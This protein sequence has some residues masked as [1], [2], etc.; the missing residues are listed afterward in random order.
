MCQLSLRNS[1]PKEQQISQR[2]SHQLLE[3]SAQRRRS[4]G[5]VFGVYSYRTDRLDRSSITIAP[6][7]GLESQ[8]WGYAGAYMQRFGLFKLTASIIDQTREK[9]YL[10][11][12]YLSAVAKKFQYR[13]PAELNDPFDRH[14]SH[15][16]T[17]SRNTCQQPGAI[18]DSWPRPFI[19]WQNQPPRHS[20]RTI[21][22]GVSA[23]GSRDHC[24]LQARQRVLT[25]K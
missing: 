19:L 17:D 5:N 22:E 9:S 7:Y 14:G 13:L 11:R 6:T 23:Q 25:A 12:D 8:N 24:N 10:S 3:T 16:E 1:N 18:S 15:E 2:V 20:H 21:L 4:R